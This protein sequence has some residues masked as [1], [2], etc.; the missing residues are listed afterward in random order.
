MSCCWGVHCFPQEIIP[1]ADCSRGE[2]FVSK[3][4]GTACERTEHLLLCILSHCVLGKSLNKTG[5]RTSKFVCISGNE[6]VNLVGG[7]N[8][9]VVN[10]TVENQPTAIFCLELFS[11]K[12]SQNY[13]KLFLK[14]GTVRLWTLF[15][16]LMK[17][18]SWKKSVSL[19]LCAKTQFNCRKHKWKRCLHFSCQRSYYI[20][21]ASTSTFTIPFRLTLVWDS[22]TS[23]IALLHNS[24]PLFFLLL[25]PTH[26]LYLRGVCM[27]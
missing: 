3:P 23:L 8:Y 1:V 4:K 5:S 16:L 18:T 13:H 26:M 24:V 27:F 2:N 22:F 7:E 10:R 21:N 12:E 15:L 19:P 25:L 11:H 14:E 6:W 17:N 9:S 20:S